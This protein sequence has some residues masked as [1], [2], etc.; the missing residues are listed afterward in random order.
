MKTF[1]KIALAIFTT[2]CFAT[3]V[4]AQSYEQKEEMERR[5]AE[6][7]AQMNDYISFMASK[8]KTRQNRIYYSTKALNLFVGRGH[9]YEENGIQKDGVMMEITSVNRK[10]TS[11]KLIR[12][13]FSALI[14]LK[15]TDI[16][17]TS[18]DIADIKISNLQQIGE[19]LYVCTCQFDQAFVGYRDGRPVY[20][21]VTTKRV[22]C[23][24]IVEE[25]EDGHD[26]FIV[27]LGD[28]TALSTK[29]L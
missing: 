26:E 20:K 14:D 3:S 21:D 23:Y 4:S 25:V 5:A 27:M 9:E 12:D 1:N 10:N 22:K 11:H 24:V 15:Y 7:V 17:I 8:K 6:R 28:V 29:R 16:Q 13:Y 2:L 18:T 19:N